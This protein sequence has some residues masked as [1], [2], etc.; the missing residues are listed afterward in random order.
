M[1]EISAVCPLFT[2]KRRV[3]LDT[4]PDSKLGRSP[5]SKIFAIPD[6]HPKTRGDVLPVLLARRFFLVPDA[7][8]IEKWCTR[9]GRE[10]RHI[11]QHQ[12]HEKRT[13]RLMANFLLRGTLEQVE[14]ER[15]SIQPS[16]TR[17]TFSGGE[18]GAD[19]RASMIGAE[20]RGGRNAP[21]D[22]GCN[23]HGLGKRPQN[24][25]VSH[26]LPAFQQGGAYWFCVPNFVEA[27]S[28]PRFGMYVTRPRCR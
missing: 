27:E 20:T 15:D 5:A 9:I 8:L 18:S 25:R 14:D 22:L 21:S 1:I 19:K 13:K 17:K 24:L 3:R 10:P 7:A 16:L 4:E 23:A 2:G 11:D 26:P 28:Y 6:S 12:A